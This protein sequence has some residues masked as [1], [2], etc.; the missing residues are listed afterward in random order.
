MLSS[1]RFAANSI[2]G[3]GYNFASETNG[4]VNAF[5]GDV[6]NIL[7]SNEGM[8]DIKAAFETIQN[9]YNSNDVIAFFFSLSMNKTIRDKNVPIDFLSM[10]SSNDKYK[11]VFIVFYGAILYYVANMMKAKGIALPQT[12]AFSG[13]GS[14]T[15]NV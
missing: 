13:N 8:A 4:F 5:K 11:Y 3:D 2:F 15:L 9:R 7:N 10:L 14:K 1:F 6:L 12:L